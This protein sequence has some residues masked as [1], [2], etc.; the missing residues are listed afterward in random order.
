MIRFIS[1]EEFPRTRDLYEQAF[2]EDSRE[3]VDYYY[4]READGNEAIVMDGALEGPA[5]IQVMIH[6][7]YY[8]LRVFGNLTRVPYLVAVATK[9]GCRGQGRMGQVMQAALQELCGRGIPF[10]FL[11]PKDPAYYAGVGFVFFPWEDPG[12]REE[13]ESH[14]KRDAP[15]SERL[16]LEA[17]GSGQGFSRDAVWREMADFSNRILGKRYDI[18]IER[19]APYYERLRRETEAAGG[20]ILLRRQDGELQ[21]ILSYGME[22]G[23]PDVKEALPCR[24]V[25]FRAMCREAFPREEAS[26]SPMRMMA[27]VTCLSSFVPL[28]KS[29]RQKRLRVEVS[30]P[31]VEENNGCYEILLGPEG[32]SMRQIPRRA[33]ETR[34]DIAGLARILLADARVFLNEWV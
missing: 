17:V 23:K 12:G 7:N 10:T 28:V 20:E 22:D 1:R 30:D 34:M 8:R 9:E 3:F 14:G 13:R 2:P 32:G 15:Y 21:G 33:A 24:D 27:R 29:E 18:Y 11:L 25:D 6:L 16:R 5:G 26:F 19:D 31:Q 4:G